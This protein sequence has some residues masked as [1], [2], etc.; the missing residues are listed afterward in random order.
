MI[1]ALT[2]TVA[3]SEWHGHV[4]IRSYRWSRI[5]LRVTDGPRNFNVALPTTMQEDV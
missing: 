5:L 3:S 2:A 1:Q 4:S